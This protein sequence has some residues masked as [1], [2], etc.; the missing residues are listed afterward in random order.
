[1]SFL[2]SLESLTAKQFIIVPIHNI[3]LSIVQCSGCIVPYIYYYLLYFHIFK[4]RKCTMMEIITV[5]QMPKF[6]MFSFKT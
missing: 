2:R 6:I 4:W 5:W 3:M 1:M